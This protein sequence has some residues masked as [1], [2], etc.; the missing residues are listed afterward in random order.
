MRVFGLI[1]L[2]IFVLCAE[3]FLGIQS[4]FPEALQ[5]GKT[6]IVQDIIENKKTIFDQLSEQDLAWIAENK[7]V[8]VGVDP[9][10]YPLETFNERGQYTGLGG[11]YLRLLTHLTGI[12]FQVHRQQDWATVEELA[13]LKRID[14]FMAVAK[15]DRR[16]EY[17]LFTDPYINMPG[18]IMAVRSSHLEGALLDDFKG[19]KVAVVKDYYWQDYVASKYPEIELVP[20]KDT[21]HAM[22]L[23]SNGNADAVIDYEFNLN[24]KIQLAGIY[25]LKAV[26]SVPSEFG[27]AVAVRN[28]LLELF[29]IINIA[30]KQITPAEAKALEDRWL[31]KAK[32]A[33][34]ERRLQWYFFFFT[35]A[36]LLVLFVIGIARSSTRK[37]VLAK[38]REMRAKLA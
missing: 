8:N 2:G 10:F 14:L 34:S 1:I 13:Q 20:A 29:D 3:V 30:L 22:Q 18:V 36:T 32:P 26:G 27:H 23:V 5:K 16:S 38:A 15:S 28:D 21:I 9:N 11:D 37:A 4:F 25:Q 33:G 6:D 17:L 24:E 31:S 19:K 35:Q 12:N 7:T